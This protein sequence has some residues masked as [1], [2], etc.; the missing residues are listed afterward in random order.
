MLSVGCH[1]PRHLILRQ[2]GKGGM[3]AVYLAHDLQLQR[4][5]ALKVPHFEP[6]EKPEHRQR[7]YREARLA[8]T[9]RHP[10]W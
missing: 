6:D 8:A 7:F 5:V 1:C 4:D 9:L 2:L 3:G 10:R